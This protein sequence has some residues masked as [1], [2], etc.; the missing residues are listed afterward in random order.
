MVENLGEKILRYEQFLNERLRTDLQKVLKLREEVYSDVTEYGQLKTTVDLLVNEGLCKKDRPLK[1]MVDL[2]CNFY[3]SAKVEDC[4][5]IFVSIGLG[6]YL[7]M[8]LEEASVFVADKVSKLSSKAENLSEQ[9]A[10]ING[11]IKMV[12]RTLRQL[13]FPVEGDVNPPKREI[14]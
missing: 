13:Q 5:T 8:K 2:G 3:T 9:A 14:W 12:M 10:Q 4:S 6:F 1:T 11:R 7:E